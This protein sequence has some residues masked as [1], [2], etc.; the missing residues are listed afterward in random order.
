MTFQP[1]VSTLFKILTDILDFLPMFV[2]GLLVLILG[3]L[4]CVV[5]RWIVRF[6]LRHIG[7]DQLVQRAGIT[8]A[9]ESLGMRLPLSTV[10]A[11]LVFFFC[12]LVL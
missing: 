1:V 11:Q 7:F 4:I 3:Y 5:I 10:I 6:I 2:N 9:L 8:T 12:C